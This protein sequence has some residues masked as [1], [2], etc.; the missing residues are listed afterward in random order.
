MKVLVNGA[1][2]KQC[3][4][5]IP[6]LVEAGC[7][8]YAL[9][10]MPENKDRL[11]DMGVKEV[12]IGDICRDEVIDR[13]LKGMDTIYLLVPEFLPDPVG[14]AKRVIDKAI[15]ENVEHFVFSSVLNVVPELA[16]HEEKHQIESYLMGSMINYTILKPSC[17]LDANYPVGPWTEMNYESGELHTYIGVDQPMN[18]I[19]LNDITDAACKV[20]TEGKAHYFASYELCSEGHY[21][22]R[23]IAELAGKEAGVEI[24]ITRDLIPE[25]PTVHGR[26]VLGRIVTYHSNHPFRGNTFTFNNLMGRS[27]IT[28]PEF[29]K[30]KVAEDLKK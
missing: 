2:G 9:D 22:Y 6:K 24:S 7:E 23:Q 4:V 27:A 13:A 5:L 30:R 16:Q 29:V 19:T 11:Y 10:L 21:S 17:Y 28:V 3:S 26:D 25:V 8:V 14:M 15:Q 12:I 20:I 1:G 18:W